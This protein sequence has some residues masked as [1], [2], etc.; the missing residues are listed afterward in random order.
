MWNIFLWIV[1]R[2]SARVPVVADTP[3]NHGWNRSMFLEAAKEIRVPIV[4][5]ALQGDLDVLLHRAQQRAASGEIHELKARFSVNPRWYY[6]SR[7]RSVLPEEQ[8]LRVDTTDLDGVDVDAL[9]A[10]VRD[11]LAAS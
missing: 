11:R 3:F 1:Q 8:V 7:Y 4:E 2:V 5:V 6:E 9:A 10:D